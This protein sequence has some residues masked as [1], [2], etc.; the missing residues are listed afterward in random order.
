[1]Y[2]S[3][4]HRITPSGVMLLGLLCL[5][6]TGMASAPPPGYNRVEQD[7]PSL[8]YTGSWQ[9]VTGSAYSGGSA[10]FS[11]EVGDEVEF[12]FTGTAVRWIGFRGLNTGAAQ[13]SLDGVQVAVVNTASKQPQYQAVLYAVT[14]LTQ[15]R[16]ALVIKVKNPGKKPAPMGPGASPSGVWVDAFDELPV[17]S[18]TT[19]PTASIIEPANGA[20]LSGVV[21]VSADA[22]DNVGVASV[23]FQLDTAPLGSP[24]TAAPYSLSWNSGSVVNG[25]HTL[26]AVARDA[27]GNIGTSQ[28][29]TV[30]V[31]NGSTRI[32][33][34]NP[35]VTYTGIWVTASDPTVSGGTAIESNQ[36][37]ATATLSFSGTQVSWIGY[38][39]ACAAG[40]A[41]VSVDGGSPV[42]VD[43][44]SATTQPQ[45]VVYTSPI[46]PRGNHT[47]TITVTGQY[48]RAGN[49]AYVVVDAFDVSN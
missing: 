7:D 46:L 31:S 5:C 44:Y 40:F 1:M 3:R 26:V 36:A 42:Q 20:T 15:A 41:E 39:C 34:D 24:I 28:P 38:R 29:V 12:D 16:H 8:L 23:Q 27:A 9:T 43:N 22:S 35:A 47:L 25:S 33:Q 13:V 11:T 32:E 17:S 19:P 2:T 6:G 14:G 37:D 10:A 21:T 4:S 30:T 49:S 18:D 45:A 48:D